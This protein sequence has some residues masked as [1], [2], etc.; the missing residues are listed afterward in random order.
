MAIMEI[1]KEHV[2][3]STATSGLLRVVNQWDLTAQGVNIV[4]ASSVFVL[5]GVTLVELGFWSPVAVVVAALGV[6]FVLLSFA[7]AA[8]RCRET[9]GPYRYT[10]DAFGEYVGTQVGIL[11]W[12]VRATATAAV[13]NVFVTYTAELWPS[14]AKP[15]WR[16]V[17]LS[18]AIFGSCY[19]NVRGT[20]QAASVLNFLTV[21]KVLPL[22][23]LC[24]I[25]FFSLPWGRFILTPLP[26]ATS[27]ARAV[28]LW[29]FAFGGFEATLIPAAEARNPTRDMPRALLK[30]LAIV[31]VIYVAVQVLVAGF[32]PALPSSRPVGDVAHILLGSAGAIGTAI[33]AILATNGHIGSSTLVASR[34]TFAI[35]ERGRLPPALSRIHPRFKTPAISIVAFSILVWLLAVSGSFIWNASVSAVGRLTVFE[36][37]LFANLKLRRSKASEFVV[38][39][40]VHLLAV[41]FCAWLF[42]YQTLDEAL[43]VAS[44]IIVSSAFWFIWPSIE[45]HRYPSV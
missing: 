4:L 26:H 9:G 45:K 20:R 19:L 34:I 6:M 18:V 25:G 3:R 43:C 39:I 31:T 22:V 12:V 17:L 8:G 16:I 13:S 7:E 11:F 2:H 35:A 30:A 33:V 42:L 38:P 1:V 28:L 44:V 24:S 40:W 29:V 15:G 23:V 37:T 36:F 41:A 5:P 32:L 10:A 14:A 21:V 27:W